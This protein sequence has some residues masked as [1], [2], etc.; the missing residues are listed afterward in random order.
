M[1]RRWLLFL[2]LC[3]MPAP[4]LA[5]DLVADLSAH[6][7]R[8]TTGFAGATLIVFGSMDVPADVAVVIEGPAA[9][10]TIL[11]KSRRLGIWVNTDSFVFDDVPGYYAIVSSKPAEMLAAPGIVAANGLSLDALRFSVPA[12]G[13]SAKAELFRKALVERRVARGLYREIPGGAHVLSGRLFRAAVPL[14]ANVPIGIYTVHIYLLREGKVVASQTTSLSVDEIG[15]SA[16]VHQAAEFSPFFYACAA[17]AMA[18]V[19][20]GGGA[21]LFHKMGEG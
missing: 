13:D 20:G 8:V 5:G 9:K 4:A 11:Q 1:M 17:L 6:I 21:W 12:D 15:F 7:V 16:A 19:M 2:L 14:P 18:L 10:A 3:A